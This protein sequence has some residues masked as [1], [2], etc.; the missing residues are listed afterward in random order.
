M[1]LH[2]NSKDSELRNCLGRLDHISYA[3][4]LDTSCKIIE[5]SIQSMRNYYV[6]LC[7]ECPQAQWVTINIRSLPWCCNQVSIIVLAASWRIDAVIGSQ[8]LHRM[9]H[10]WV[11]TSQIFHPRDYFKF[12]VKLTTWS[13]YNCLYFVSFECVFAQLR[14]QLCRCW[15]I[16][17]N[18]DWIMVHRGHC[19]SNQILNDGVLFGGC[20]IHR[21]VCKWFS[22]SDVHAFVHVEPTQ[23]DSRN[24]LVSSDRCSDLIGGHR[25]IPVHCSCWCTWPQ[26]HK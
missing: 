15:R 23:R 4:I 2:S 8:L 12:F 11:I 19:Q 13:V 6:L 9:Q 25:V 16:G 5:I 3:E 10:R 7:M 14:W 20:I 22:H 17:E 18:I 1:H 21:A 24:V 26:N